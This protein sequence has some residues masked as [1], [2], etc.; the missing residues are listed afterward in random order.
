[1]IYQPIKV[2]A[3]T[4]SG[5][6]VYDDY[7]PDL[8]GILEFFWLEERNL[9]SVNPTKNTLVFADIPVHKHIL[10][11][12]VFWNQEISDSDWV[13]AIS[14]PVYRYKCER[15]DQARKRWDADYNYPV[16]WG[17]RKANIQTNGGDF[18]S[19]DVPVPIRITDKVSWYL[20]GEIEEIKQLLNKCTSLG[21]RRAMGCG[22]VSRWEIVEYDQDYSLVRNGNLMTALP[23]IHKNNVSFDSTKTTLIRWNTHAPR[24][25]KRN[26]TMCYMPVGLCQEDFD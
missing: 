24:W 12:D 23:Q 8:G 19:A 6:S 26:A 14:A 17:K 4:P 16:T 21:K 25:E 1:M 22:Q 5:L 10:S 3:F 15:Q 9:L 18:K 11:K 2:T 20:I 7:T 13:W